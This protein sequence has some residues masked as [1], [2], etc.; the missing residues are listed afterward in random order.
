M[1]IRLEHDEIEQ[2]IEDYI[3]KNYNFGMQKD[4]ELGEHGIVPYFKTTQ[5][6]PNY[7]RDGKV[8][9]TEAKFLKRLLDDFGL[10]WKLYKEFLLGA[11]IPSFGDTSYSYEI[12]DWDTEIETCALDQDTSL[13]IYVATKKEIASKEENQND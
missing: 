7:K 2:A 11:R 9:K 10:S 4:W 13:T 6:R 1:Y 12:D 5:P 8:T 3:N